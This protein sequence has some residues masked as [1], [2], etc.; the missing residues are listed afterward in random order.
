MYV[1]LES[2]LEMIF[3]ASIVNRCA[4]G[5]GKNGKYSEP[6]RYFMDILFQIRVHSVLVESLFSKLTYTKKTRNR[7]D[8][9]SLKSLA[10]IR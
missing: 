3:S 1:D 7:M 4:T 5:L 10:I 2:Y 6:T 8:V 9:Q